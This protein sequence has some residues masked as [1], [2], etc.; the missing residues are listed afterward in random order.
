MPFNRR[1]FLIATTAS[2]LYSALQFQAQAVIPEIM[3][4]GKSLKVSG[5][6]Y[7][8]EWN[9]EDDRFRLLDQQ[10]GEIFSAP[11]QPVISVQQNGARKA[12]SGALQDYRL[13][14]NR[15][16]W[17]YAGEAG[18]TTVAW[19]FDG[20]GIWIEPVAFES[21]SSVDIVS[22]NLFSAADGEAAKPA[23]AAEYLVIPGNSESNALSPI[24][25]TSMG[26]QMKTS[27]GRAGT[28]I[29]Q[30]WALP[31]HFFTGF[32]GAPSYAAVPPKS[33][34]SQS[35]CCGLSEIPNADL[36]LEQKSRRCQLIF[37][38]RGDLWG[39]MRGPGK[40]T[41]GGGLYCCLAPNYRD[42]IRGYY[43]GLIGAGIVRPKINSGKKNAAMLSPQ[44]CTWGEQVAVNK[45][46][47]LL[48]QKALQQFYDELK[49]SGMKAGMLSVDW[50]WE[51][52]YGSLTHS[53]TRLPHFEQFLDR[54]RADGMRIGIWAAFLR[55]EDP[56]VLGLTRK[57]MLLKRD[58]T[59]YSLQEEEV[60]YYILD[61]THP[62]VEKVMRERARSFMKRYKP[63][64]VKFDFGY[65]IP[66]LD[67]VAPYDKQ[68]C[69]ERLLAKGL[70]VVVG[71]MK[72]ENPDV[73][74]MYYH[75]SPL[76][77]EHLDLH[78]SDDLLME[79]G[80][81]E[82]EA[83]RRF[84]FSSLCGEFGMPTYGS[85][86]YDWA[87]APDMWF[88]SIPTGTIG[89]LSTFQGPDI[90]G[91]RPTPQMFATFNGLTHLVR[92]ANQFI[93]EPLDPIF[94]P[95][96]RGAH[97]SSWA[98]YENGKVVLVALRTQRLDGG[99]GKADFGGFLGTTAPV[100]IS[101]QTEESLD[102]ATKLGVVPYGA[103]QLT[104]KHKLS[105]MVRITEHY[106]GGGSMSRN[107]SPEKGTL[108]VPLRQAGNDGVPL[109]WIAIEWLAS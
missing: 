12:L 72:Q 88:D 100:V 53:P 45:Y 107:V 4:A 86:G 14:H 103:G 46:G 79:R 34:L 105:G 77:T 7:A 36:F 39:H 28:G 78:S 31:S 40:F 58:G 95:A 98:R 81:Y 97:A 48:D 43:Q 52:R 23:L 6:N 35:F 71:A 37:E 56:S 70:E 65:E 3:V 93:V 76:F 54:V 68:W 13:E 18:K 55:C 101:S 73:V 59:P 30:Q 11:L 74:V 16:V 61:I 91:G 104:L 5:K 102:Q 26:L 83:N 64:L 33:D 82:L 32:R 8:W 44:W 96:T 92:P 69:G 99:A 67:T 9:A 80:E 50:G 21:T 84:F 85:S 15:A 47:T 25:R 27:L 66:A 62:E 109:E 106:F 41:L 10:G 49:S 19:R 22:C 1:Q 60:T 90:D 63:D 51:D 29:I 17:V 24:L 87:S 2:G 94:A 89:A 42:A 75:L 57:H 38:Y 20:N 108:L